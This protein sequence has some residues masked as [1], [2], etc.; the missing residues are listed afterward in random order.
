M[1][2]NYDQRSDCDMNNVYITVI[3]T[4]LINGFAAGQPSQK[5]TLAD[6]S[7]SVIE[8]QVPNDGLT[9]I[10]VSTS[11]KLVK[12]KSDEDTVYSRY[13]VR[14][15]C[16][17]FEVLSISSPD[18]L[19][20]GSNESEISEVKS[21]YVQN[22]KYSFKID[23]TKNGLVLAEISLLPGY[24]FRVLDATVLEKT[25]RTI[26]P[27][28]II[29]GI[30]IQNLL[31]SDQYFHTDTRLDDTGNK[32]LIELRFKPLHKPT[33]YEVL[34]GT[35]QLSD[36]PLWHCNSLNF[37]R[38][39]GPLTV[40][41]KMDLGICKV[42]QSYFVSSRV[43]KGS[44]S[45]SPTDKLEQETRYTY[46]IDSVPSSRFRLSHYGLPEPEGV[47]WEKPTPRWVWFATAAGVLLILSIL[48]RWLQKRL[49]STKA[50]S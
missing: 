4:L 48:F 11:K 31:S 36:T 18:R 17:L 15:N 33:D 2:N 44:P 3:V 21:A 37:I 41:Y 35:A 1:Q 23:R 46:K 12:G 9:V 8:T 50:A 26:S 43:L 27:N 47:V 24:R 16:A 5:N 19:E 28:S 34:D 25:I 49:T 7:N 32:K 22:E 40:A 6:V 14:P 29:S 20:K 42:S 13:C 30:T 39:E 10:S 38:K 45:S